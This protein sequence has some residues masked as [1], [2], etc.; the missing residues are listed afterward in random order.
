M[1]VAGNEPDLILL[2]EVIP[3]AQVHPIPLATLSLPG[4]T[5]YLNFEPG[6]QNLGSSGHRG[7][8]IF[9]NEKWRATKVSSPSPTFEEHLLVSIPLKKQDQL[10]VGCI[11]R[12]PSASGD[13]SSSNLI[14]LL[15]SCCSMNY[16]H[17][18]IA[19]DINMPQIEWDTGFSS[20][21]DSHYT[22]SFIEGVQEC[23]PVF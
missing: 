21:P 11:Y 4:Y 8:G 10:L 22:H 20:A 13:I 9:V 5:M 19:G 6:Q 14:H 23:G 3:K 17:M 2:T 1:L 12:S 15:K 7:I 16:S 18:V